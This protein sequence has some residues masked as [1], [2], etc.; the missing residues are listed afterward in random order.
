MA[1]FTG[2]PASASDYSK[3]VTAPIRK[4]VAANGV[5]VKKFATYTHALGTGTGAVNL[6]TLPQ[7]TYWVYPYLSTIVTSAWEAN[8][9]VHLGYRAYL[10]TDGTTATEDDNAFADNVDAATGGTFNLTLPPVL[11]EAAEPV[12]IFALIDTG[13]IANDDTLDVH[14][15]YAYAK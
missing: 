3:E 15:A 2:T 12:V 5:Q 6:G 7:G 9:D 13:D 14:L 1:A 11:I 8:A 10:K 4:T